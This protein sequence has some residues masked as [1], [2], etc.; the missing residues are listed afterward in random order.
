MMM[1]KLLIVDDEPDVADGLYSIFRNT[2]RLELDIYKAY[3]AFEALDILSRMK[4][5][6]L[7]TDI[8]MPGMTGL[9]LI[10]K[11]KSQWPDC[12]VIFLT[13]HNEFDYI[14]SAIKFEGVAYLLKTESFEKIVECVE[15]AALQIKN[16]VEVSE[17]EDK[18]SNYLNTLIPYM[19]KEYITGLIAEQETTVELRSQQ[20]KELKIPLNHEQPVLLLI[21]RLGNLN[22][23]ISLLEKTRMLFTI[24][25]I[26][27]RHFSPLLNAF[28]S[29]P[30][31]FIV[32]WMIQPRELGD[33]EGGIMKDTVWE[34]LP[35]IVKDCAETIQNICIDSFDL[36]VSFIVDSE[37]TSWEKLASRYDSLKLLLHNYIGLG[38]ELLLLD[39]EKII[40][41]ALH[42]STFDFKKL[43]NLEDYLESGQKEEFFTLFTELSNQLR[44][45]ES[46]HFNPSLEIF[47]SVS[48][49]F[50]SYINR[51][52]LTDKVAFKIGLNK[53]T[54][55]DDH[56][57]W[58]D[59]VSYFMELADILF[60]ISNYNDENNAITA[61]QK[62]KQYIAEHLNEDISLARMAEKVYFNPSYLSR[63][64]KQITGTNLS[65]YTNGVRLDKAK[66]LLKNNDMKI[67]EIAA[68]VGYESAS[69]FTQFFK[70]TLKIS[71]QEYRDKMM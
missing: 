13:G 47:Y 48:L 35:N 6:I 33:I 62:V 66:E 59:A 11:V 64:F 2:E 38:T 54:R 43:R 27:E 67:H 15:N 39:N 23:H 26:A 41:G 49:M 20:F 30:E 36:A 51:Y 56:S 34:K 12:R 69:Y 16:S 52:S 19:Q 71:P 9:Q 42:N 22:R 28:Y 44:S 61:V 58:E 37:A 65:S 18:A 57:T 70:R 4:I 3:S 8:F 29:V 60:S 25:E 46:K 24:K 63:L 32:L 21:G 68:A 10:E 14:Y 1:Y 17:L 5:D 55:V 50:L 31:R 53:L 40:K 45:V 7:I